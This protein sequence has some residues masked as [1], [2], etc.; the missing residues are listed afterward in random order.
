VVER[1]SWA[2]ES[3]YKGSIEDIEGKVTHIK[4]VALIMFGEFLEQ[5]G[6]VDSHLYAKAFKKEGQRRTKAL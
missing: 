1:A 5:K 4:G 2:D 6:S 3:V